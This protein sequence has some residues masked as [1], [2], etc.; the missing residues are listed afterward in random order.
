M[1][2]QPIKDLELSYSPID[3][4]IREAIARRVSARLDFNYTYDF[5]GEKNDE[6]A[7]EFSFQ[8]NVEDT[9]VSFLSC[10]AQRQ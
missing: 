6:D 8:A 1:E 5:G 10:P 9:L 7:T 4:E 2:Q 3:P